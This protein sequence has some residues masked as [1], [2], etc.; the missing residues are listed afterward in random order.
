MNRIISHAPL[1]ISRDDG[2]TQDGMTLIPWSHGKPVLWD[3]TI[4]DTLAA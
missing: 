4:I 2:K 3:A 1:G